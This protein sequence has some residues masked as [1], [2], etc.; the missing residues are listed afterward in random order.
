[1]TEKPKVLFTWTNHEMR[2]ALEDGWEQLILDERAEL[3]LAEFNA[4]T[5]PKLVVWGKHVHHG[6][7]FSIPCDVSFSE[8]FP[9]TGPYREQA[10]ARR[11]FS[12]QIEDAGLW[13]KSVS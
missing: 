5:I 2:E 3:T 4:G 8:S 7:R 12:Q 9:T 1:M 6:F 10:L 11:P 13:P